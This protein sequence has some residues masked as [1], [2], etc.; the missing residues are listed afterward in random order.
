[1]PAVRRRTE[2]WPTSIPE[3]L[4]WLQ[5]ARGVE[6]LPKHERMY[7]A[8]VKGARAAFLES[9]FWNEL[10]GRLNAIDQDYQLMHGLSLILPPQGQVSLIPEV[11]EKSWNSFLL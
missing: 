7:L 9:P 10:T 2:N 4:A 8:A 11:Q 1:M 6:H 5:H 3:Y